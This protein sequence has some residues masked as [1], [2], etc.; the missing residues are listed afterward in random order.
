MD[1]SFLQQL[2][3]VHDWYSVKEWPEQAFKFAKQFNLEYKHLIN[4]VHAFGQTYYSWV[5][6]K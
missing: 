6:K 3:A 5:I 2:Q 4:I 1:S